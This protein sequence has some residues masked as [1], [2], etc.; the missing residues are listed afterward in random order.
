LQTHLHKLNSPCLKGQ[1]QSNN[2]SASLKRS[3]C[4]AGKKNGARYCQ[5]W[6]EAVDGLVMGLCETERYARH[7]CLSVGDSECVD[8][9]YTESTEG[10]NQAIWNNQLR[11]GP[12]PIEKKDGLT[13][14]EDVFQ[15]M[16]VTLK[17][18]GMSEKKLFYKMESKGTLSCGSNGTF[19]RNYLEKL[20]HEIWPDVELTDASPLAVY[21]EKT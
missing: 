9:F 5:Y 19:V 10:S 7:S 13:K 17:V 15:K 12:I 16:N 18:L 6:R 4:E 21:G 2:T 1:W 11:W 14:I 20:V 8:V 3:G